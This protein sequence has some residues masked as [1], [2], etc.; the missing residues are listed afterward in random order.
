MTSAPGIDDI[1]YSHLSFLASLFNKTTRLGFISS[2]Q[3][4]YKAGV[5]SDP[6]YG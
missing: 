3:G 5:I 1:S 6:T 2:L 4:I